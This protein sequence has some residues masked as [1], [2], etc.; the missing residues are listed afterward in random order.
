MVKRFNWRGWLKV[1]PA[2]KRAGESGILGLPACIPITITANVPD[3]DR[4]GGIFPPLSPQKRHQIS[5]DQPFSPPVWPELW[6]GVKLVRNLALT[7]GSK[8]FARSRGRAAV[9]AGERCPAKGRHL[10]AVPSTTPVL[11][12]RALAESIQA[13]YYGCV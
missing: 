3:L 6:A 7:H 4:G 1:Q 5:C 12:V 13:P 2:L 10:L 8:C 11:E 9:G